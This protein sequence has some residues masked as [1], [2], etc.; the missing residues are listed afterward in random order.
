MPRWLPLGGLVLAMH[1]AVWL[2]LP[3]A[4]PLPLAVPA[5]PRPLVI[6]VV[7]PPEPL[8]QKAI[9]PPAP[10]PQSAKAPAA[11]RAPVPA[12]ALAPRSVPAPAAV[13]DSHAELSPVVPVDSTPRAEVPVAAKS[14]E[15]PAE[16]AAY[17]RAGYR[18]NPPPRYPP[19]ALEQGW[20]GT[21]LLR[22]RVLADGRPDSVEVQSG[23]GRK[24]LDDAAVQTVKRWLF[25][26]ARRGDA[27]VDGWASV[28]I[29]FKLAS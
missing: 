12:A 6:E 25:N 26:P 19:V 3:A 27:P 29:V 9:K 10:L 22:V 1:A 15:A 28:P 13:A 20:E 17:G 18:N 2:A 24:V 7:K 4:T 11:P 21:V 5:P 14:S 8:Q 23:S 16:T